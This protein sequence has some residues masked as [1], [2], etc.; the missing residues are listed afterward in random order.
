MPALHPIELDQ[1]REIGAHVHMT[2][3][4]R[5]HHL[6]HQWMVRMQYRR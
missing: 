4:Q 2:D 5:F 3:R 1:E 6:Q